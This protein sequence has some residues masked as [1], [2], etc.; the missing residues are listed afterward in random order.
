MIQE[1]SHAEIDKKKFYNS[2]QSVQFNNLQ[3]I[4][5]TQGF[6]EKRGQAKFFFRKGLVDEWKTEVPKNILKTIEKEFNQEMKELGY[7]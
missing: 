3:N 2:L 7:L 1:K 5:K 4:E 6:E